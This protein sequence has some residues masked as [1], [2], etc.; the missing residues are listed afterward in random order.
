MARAKVFQSGNSQAVR[1][2]KEFRFKT[3]EVEIERRGSEVVLRNK[4]ETLAEF[5]ETLT[6][7]SDD[8]MKGGRRQPVPQK[9][10]GL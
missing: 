8:F 5:F 7:L 10:K 3:R 9:R 6:S 2:P 1:L 4:R